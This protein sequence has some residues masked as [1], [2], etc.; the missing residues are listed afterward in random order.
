M[1]GLGD[2]IRNEYSEASNGC[3]EPAVVVHI[4]E[5][6]SLVYL[7]FILCCNSNKDLEYET[8]SIKVLRY[9]MHLMHFS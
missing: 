4:G 2:L 3:W 8:P 9:L 1:T 6:G 7:R 5:V